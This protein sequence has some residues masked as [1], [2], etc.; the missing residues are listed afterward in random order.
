[1]L[2]MRFQSTPVIA[3]GRINRGQLSRP[4]QPRFNPRPLLLTGESGALTMRRE[5]LIAVS[6]HAR[7]C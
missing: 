6:I 1:M 5:L 4:P 7:Y 3:N 2:A